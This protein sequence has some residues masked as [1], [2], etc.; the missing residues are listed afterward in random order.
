MTDRPS[1]SSTPPQPSQPRTEAGRRLVEERIADYR[2][3]LRD[4]GV[5]P[6][7]RGAALV[8]AEYRRDWERTVLAIEAEAATP[9]T[10]LD[11]ERLAR[12]LHVN[13]GDRSDY[14]DCPQ[15]RDGWHR[16][17]AEILAAEYAR[18]TPRTDAE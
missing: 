2:A 18:L 11:V 4:G 8:T 6:D 14:D 16:R 10:G 13:V 12:A 17:T 1:P 15:T 9:S 7:E 3:N 5:D